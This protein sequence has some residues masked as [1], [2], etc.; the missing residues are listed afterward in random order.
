MPR[1][2]FGM[3]FKR[4][5]AY[6]LYCQFRDEEGAGRWAAGVGL[7]YTNLKPRLDTQLPNS[8]ISYKDF[9]GL[10]RL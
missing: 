4:S 1:N 10:H 3:D 5:P 7:F 6:E 2:E 8:G 9:P